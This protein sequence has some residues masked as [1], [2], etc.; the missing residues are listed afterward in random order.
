MLC[1]EERASVIVIRYHLLP[2]SDTDPQE[3]PAQPG[4][5]I[6]RKT[7]LTRKNSSGPNKDMSESTGAGD[8]KDQGMKKHKN[9]DGGKTDNSNKGKG[10]AE[11]QEGEQEDQG[12]RCE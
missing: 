1:G 3:A 11:C 9:T 4:K 5:V 6:G 10:T 12:Q 7:S 8:I 2:S